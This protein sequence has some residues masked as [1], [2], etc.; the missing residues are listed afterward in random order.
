MVWIPPLNGIAMCQ[1]G[2]VSPSN[3]EGIHTITADP[4]RATT[5]GPPT[6]QRRDGQQNRSDLMAA[7]GEW[8][9]LSSCVNNE[10][11]CIVYAAHSNAKAIDGTMI[12]PNRGRNTPR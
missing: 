8:R 6:G 1:N 7:L 12:K 11:H 4:Q 5:Q 9:K 10:Q 3:E 2:D